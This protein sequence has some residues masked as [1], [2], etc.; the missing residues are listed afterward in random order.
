MKR[1]C[2]ILAVIAI[3]GCGT[4]KSHISISEPKAYTIPDYGRYSFNQGRERTWDAIVANLSRSQFKIDKMDKASYHIA[5][6]IDSDPSKYIDCGSRRITKDETPKR[7]TNAASHYTYSKYR[8]NHLDTYFVKNDLTS[9]VN[10]MVGGDEMRSN[11]NVQIIFTLNVL[12]RRTTTQGVQFNTT[13]EYTL[14]LTPNESKFFDAYGTHC[15][16]K[17]KL[18]QEIRSLLTAS[19]SP[20]GYQ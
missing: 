20:Y 9:D 15:R 11:A 13:K 18:E 5:L 7:V 4:P 12:E 2:S 1:V 10:I 19:Y 8:D 14:T 6:K 16:S 17:G 3:S